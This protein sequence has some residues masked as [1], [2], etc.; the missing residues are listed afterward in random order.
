MYMRDRCKAW[1]EQNNPDNIRVYDIYFNV[2]VN[3]SREVLVHPWQHTNVEDNLRRRML[4]IAQGVF[5]PAPDCM[6]LLESADSSENDL[7][8]CYQCHK[9]KAFCTCT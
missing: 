3:V 2:Y 5:H 1:E 4:A 8:Y 9:D 7:N 6:E